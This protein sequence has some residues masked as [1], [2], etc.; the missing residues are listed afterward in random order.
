MF[1]QEE[2]YMSKTF[3]ELSEEIENLFFTGKVSEG[4]EF[5]TKVLDE[6]KTLDE[7]YLIFFESEKACYVEKDYEKQLELLN[8]LIEI[9]SSD[10]FLL[11]KKG[12]CLLNM[13]KWDNA[14][15][16][17]DDVLKIEPANYHAMLGKG[18]SL[19]NMGERDDA[20]KNFEDAEAIEPNNF[21]V[22]NNQA[23]YLSYM[24]LQDEALKK[25]DEALKI[26]P[27]DYR[28]ICNKAMSLSEMGLQDEAI[29]LFDEALKIEPED[30]NNIIKEFKGI[31]L[32]RMGFQEKSIRL[33]EEILKIKPD[34]SYAMR[35][36]GIALSRMG[37]EE[38]AIN[39]F[40]E[41]LKVKPDDYETIRSKGVSLSKR[42]K[43]KDAIK[44]FDEALKIK[45]DDYLSFYFK[46]KAFFNLGDQKN[47][48][49]NIEK[50][51]SLN[52]NI[53][54]KYAYQ[55]ISR[56]SNAKKKEIIREV[57]DEEKREELLAIVGRVKQNMQD[58]FE[59]FL[60]T[61][62]QTKNN[63]LDFVISDSKFCDD[64][65]FFLLLRQWN[66]F[67]PIIPISGDKKT[68]HVGGGYFIFHNNKG[69]VIDPGYNFIENFFEA[70]GKI[71]N[72]N[73]IILTHAH[74][75]HTID[76]E[77]LLAL[78]H[79]YNQEKQLTSND[80]D[81]KRINLY[82]NTGALVK[83]AGML[84][85]KTSDYIN[86]IYT[87]TPG[88]IYSLGDGM[89]LYALDAYHD[90]K[91]TTEKY[92]VG[93]KFEFSKDKDRRT[94]LFTSDTG[95]FPLK[96]T[97]NLT[98]GI[99]DVRA[100]EIWKK[101]DKRKRIIDLLVAHIGS[102]RESE[103]KTGVATREEEIYYPNHLGMIGTARI[104]TALKPRLAVISEFGEELKEIQED[105]ISSI[106][107]IVKE[108]FAKDPIP[109]VL[110]GDMSFIYDIWDRTIYCINGKK[111]I[112]YEDIICRR[113]PSTGEF[114]YY[115]KGADEFKIPN[116]FKE[117][118][119]DRKNLKLPYYKK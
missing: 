12:K 61:M 35:N 97:N 11:I 9:K 84:D 90:E 10:L 77:S 52:K 21:R 28:I 70:G 45:P 46:G 1:F 104:I 88:A 95:L 49:V 54:V 44:F 74:N 65:T 39:L 6:A 100:D 101:Y 67:T 107:D 85:I 60:H 40:D 62:R 4:K 83:F 3:E 73:N 55:Y 91:I 42:G 2:N 109:K 16:V 99:V 14:L 106:S 7:S 105:L 53:R 69:T 56:I 13:E 102:I 27:N 72:I 33:F 75:D 68:R 8:K 23:N 17:F 119:E 41:A 63:Y 43:Q 66:S 86:M 24:G 38:E 87:L 93:L 71:Q 32:S 117:F 64:M 98:E 116:C 15:K 89:K 50:A 112:T 96:K 25:F 20:F 36:K 113:D 59:K 57:P 115:K 79:E 18:S 76:L 5:L 22:L 94:L 31:V 48:L 34:D 81:Y 114:C 118:K 82:L 78:I 26:N 30:R 108:S 110:P 51:H 92:A 37:R 111:M 80:V 58:K 29:E 19:L 103:F 47:A